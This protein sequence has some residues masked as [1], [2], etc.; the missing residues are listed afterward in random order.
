MRG[1]TFSEGSSAYDWGIG[2]Y[3]NGVPWTDGGL[4]R[5]DFWVDEI[6]L[7]TDMEG[8]GAPDTLDDGGRPYIPS[9]MRVNEFAED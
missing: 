8:Y 5:T 7:A 1:R 3:W 4:G 9:N 6:I 2:N